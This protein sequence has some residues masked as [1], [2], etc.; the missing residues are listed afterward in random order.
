MQ[1]ETKPASETLIIKLDDGDLLK[2]AA[3]C[4]AVSLLGCL[5][6]IWLTKKRT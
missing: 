5:C 2:V 3:L 6:A 4:F 1:E